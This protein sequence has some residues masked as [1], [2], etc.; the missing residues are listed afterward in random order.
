MTRSG[1]AVCLAALCAVIGTAGCGKKQDKPA[2]NQN[3]A[4]TSAPAPPQETPEK[5]RAKAL[6]KN[7]V[8]LSYSLKFDASAAKFKEALKCDP[9][10]RELQQNLAFTLWRAHK[11]D[12]ARVIWKKL[13]KGQDS[14]A[15]SA[16]N[17]LSLD[18]KDV[19]KSL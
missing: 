6:F 17:F 2:A 11:V 10:N 9:E 12:E 15:Q 1:F 18:P 5:L 7:A 13:A 16:R 19:P 14:A 3:A 4:V 8:E